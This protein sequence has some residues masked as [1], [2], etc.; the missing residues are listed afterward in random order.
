MTDLE[1]HHAA[2]KQ[3]TDQER[4][5]SV[6]AAAERNARTLAAAG[7]DPEEAAV[8]GFGRAV[9]DDHR[10]RCPDHTVDRCVDLPT[11]PVMDEAPA[12]RDRVERQR[13]VLDRLRATVTGEDVKARAAAA[14]EHF[15]AERG[16]AT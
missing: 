3:A 14:V 13:Q 5:L 4:Y 9:A 6:K 16:G 8:A 12:L 7:V 1:P 10:L 15:R 2:A 11:G